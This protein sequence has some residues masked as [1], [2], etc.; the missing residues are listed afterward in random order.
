MS[1]AGLE[2]VFRAMDTHH[3]DGLLLEVAA[4]GLANCLTSP[5]AV[6]VAV[7]SGVNSILVRAL[8]CCH[9]RSCSVHCAHVFL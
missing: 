2:R 6:A 8:W 1:G 4:A 3:N 9:T 7:P 5:A